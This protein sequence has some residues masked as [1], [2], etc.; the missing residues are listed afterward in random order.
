MKEALEKVFNK[1]VTVDN[2]ANA[3]TYAV[4]KFGAGK[5]YDDMVFMTISTGIGGGLYNIF[6]I[7]NP[8]IIVL[9][10]GLMKLGSHF[11]EEIKLKFDAHAKN[12]IHDDIHIRLFELGD[13]AG[14]IGAA[15]IVMDSE[16]N[17]KNSHFNLCA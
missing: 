11:F 10:G 4:H 9:G 3:Q 6:Q 2:D 14:V 16:Q 13:S 7:F 1:T 8:P 5:N 15:A 12:M 17:N